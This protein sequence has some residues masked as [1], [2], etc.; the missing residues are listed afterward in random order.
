MPGKYD[1]SLKWP[2]KVDLTIDQHGGPNVKL[3]SLCTWINQP[4]I[5]LFLILRVMPLMLQYLAQRFAFIVL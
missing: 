4:I 2:A 5:K 1:N 3:T